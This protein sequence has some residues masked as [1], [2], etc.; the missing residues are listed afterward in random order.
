MDDAFSKEEI[1]ICDATIEFLLGIYVTIPF[2]DPKGPQKR[3]AIMRKVKWEY[4]RKAIFKMM[5]EME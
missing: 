2:S 4:Q 5:R 3:F 1:A